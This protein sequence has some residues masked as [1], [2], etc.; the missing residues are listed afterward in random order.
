[1]QPKAAFEERNKGGRPHDD[2]HTD[3]NKPDEPPEL[4]LWICML[5]G[6]CQT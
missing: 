3:Q 4:A 5:L 2:V 6:T 1:M